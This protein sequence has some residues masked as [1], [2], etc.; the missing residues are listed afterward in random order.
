M[1][2]LRFA[3]I[4]VGKYGS[5]I[6][7]EIALKGAEVLAL[8]VDAE[9]IETLKDDV[10][11]AVALDSTDKKAL[12]AQD[13]TKV[14]AAIVAIGENFEAT[15]LTSLNLLDLKIPRVIV[16]ASGENQR[17]ILK[18]LGISEILSPES[19]VATSIA[20]RLINPSIQAFLQLPD[21]FEIAE[22]K[23]PKKLANRTL[24]DIRLNQKYDLTLITLKR[25]YE[26]KDKG[27]DEPIT[28]QHIIGIPKA[29][30]V[31]Y[32]TD[33][34]IVFGSMKNIQRLI[35]INS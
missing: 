4:G 5:E 27:G 2:G 23:T 28:E 34:L 16:R 30:T 8:D 26:M 20:E 17:R 12:I 15:V 29:E 25:E 32:E 21:G 31:I 1:T 13:V 3:V 24:E 11:L 10:A 7:R 6:A 22:I 33:T 9:K 35:E 19:E 18:N 14:D